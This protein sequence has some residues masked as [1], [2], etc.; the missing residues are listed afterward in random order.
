[1]PGET[2]PTKEPLLND[3]ENLE[4]NESGKYETT[5]YRWAILTVC[6][7]HLALQ[8]L[9]LSTMTPAAVELTQAYGLK[10]TIWVNL[11]AMSFGICAIPFT[12]ISIWAFKRFQ[13]SNV[14]RIASIFMFLG[15]QLRLAG[16]YLDE[17]W[18]LLLGQVICASCA[19]FFINV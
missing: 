12:F 13:T 9:L 11:C 7:M 4:T 15:A 16:F 6:S 1:M 18:P 10:S 3:S 19:P 2:H 8:T 14:L 5:P 17:F